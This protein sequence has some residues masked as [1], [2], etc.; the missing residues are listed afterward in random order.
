VQL[1][2]GTRVQLQDALYV[3]GMAATPVSSARLFTTNGY[4]IV[5]GACVP[6]LDRQHRVVA[7]ATC[8]PNGL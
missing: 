7:L 6:T 2:N 5:F 8:Q 1:A 4:T 3:S